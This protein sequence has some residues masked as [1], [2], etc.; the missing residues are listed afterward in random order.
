[1]LDMIT[2]WGLRILYNCRLVRVSKESGI[3]FF[4]SSEIWDPER[5]Y[6]TT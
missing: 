5:A 4:F 3:F 6:P 1:M 2:D